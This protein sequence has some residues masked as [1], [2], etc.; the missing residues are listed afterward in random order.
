FLE[1]NPLLIG[2]AMR[3]R[4]R[5]LPHHL[6]C[7]AKPIIPR[8]NSTNSAHAVWPIIIPPML[9]L[10]ISLIVVFLSSVSRAD[11]T[12]QTPDVHPRL[13]DEHPLLFAVPPTEPAKD[14]FDNDTWSYDPA[15]SYITHIRSSD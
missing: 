13:L 11:F 14:A 1:V 9:A 12:I 4:P 15:R 7:D 2:P 6:A 3:D 8:K 5:N 10:R